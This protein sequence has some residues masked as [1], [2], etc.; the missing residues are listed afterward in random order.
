MHDRTTRLHVF[1]RTGN[2][3]DPYIGRIGR[4]PNQLLVHVALMQQPVDRP[5]AVRALNDQPVHCHVV[6]LPR[7]PH[8]SD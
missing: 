1:V 5:L 4:A 7:S 3:V 6:L 8:A 2:A